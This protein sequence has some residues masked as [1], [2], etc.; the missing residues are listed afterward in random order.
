MDIASS[1]VAPTLIQVMVA[2]PIDIILDEPTDTCAMAEEKAEEIVEAENERLDQLMEEFTRGF[3]PG[4]FIDEVA[5]S[6][7]G[8]LKDIF[9]GSY[10]HLL[11]MLFESDDSMHATQMKLEKWLLDRYPQVLNKID[12]ER[13]ETNITDETY[14]GAELEV[15]RKMLAFLRK[16]SDK[17]VFWLNSRRANPTKARE[18]LEASIRVIELFK[19]DFM[20]AMRMDT[21][22]RKIYNPLPVSTERTA[23]LSIKQLR[24]DACKASLSW[25]GYMDSAIVLTSFFHAYKAYT[26][27]HKPDK[28][29]AWGWLPPQG[30]APPRLS[31]EIAQVGDLAKWDFEHAT[32]ALDLLLRTALWLGMARGLPAVHLFCDVARLFTTH[33][34]SLKANEPYVRFLRHLTQTRV[35]IAGIK[36]TPP[37]PVPFKE[38]DG[39]T[40]GDYFDDVFDSDKI[41]GKDLTKTLTLNHMITAKDFKLSSTPPKC[42][43]RKKAKMIE[44][45]CVVEE[46]HTEKWPQK[47][48]ASLKIPFSRSS[49]IPLLTLRP[50]S[51]P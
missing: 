32:G 40:N 35:S 1:P 23:F 44:Q 21:E 34:P 31:A 46:N 5:N 9:P 20:A 3:D 7:P 2:E 39:N 19:S 15:L 37:T 33:K 18:Q 28:A 43:F 16:E 17:P 51:L 6:L 12:T 26:C 8:V 29:R 41:L 36:S 11:S 48:P 47:D 49:R 38:S 13:Q 27:E 45:A 42:S 50:P 25:D 10:E 4:I 24:I 30:L 14:F 22:D